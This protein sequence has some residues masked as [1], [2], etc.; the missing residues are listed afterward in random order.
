MMLAKSP[1]AFIPRIITTTLYSLLSLYMVLL[2]AG[3]SVENTPQ[4]LTSTLLGF[5]AVLALTPAFYLLD[6]LSYAMYPQIV[7]DIK[8]NGE[9]NLTK[10]L[11]TALKSWRIV[12]SV[13]AVVF[14]LLILVLATTSALGYVGA[15]TSNPLVTLISIPLTLALVIVFSILVFFTVPAAVMDG[16]GVKESFRQ[17]I[18]LGLLHRWD[19][20]KLN[21]V[22]AALALATIT[23]TFTSQITGSYTTESTA[24]FVVIRLI[25][26]IVYTY[27]NVANPLAY[28]EVKVNNF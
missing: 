12:V 9:V 2:I 25:Q 1:K 4:A 14:A 19:L 21:I 15:K 3:L 17:S 5:I 6:I 7:A 16:K 22:F 8:E 27:L 24:L 26:A 20:L 28:L 18:R 13:A 11:K 10:A 23:L